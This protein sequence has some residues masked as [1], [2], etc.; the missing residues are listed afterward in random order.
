MSG[1]ITKV[2]AGVEDIDFG[3]GTVTQPRGV[4]R[5]VNAEVIPFSGSEQTSDMVSIAQRIQDI[6]T[7]LANSN[8]ALASQIANSI[9]TLTSSSSRYNFISSEDPTSQTTAGRGNIWF[10]DVSLYSW[11]CIDDTANA[12]VWRNQQTQAIIQ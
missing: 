4:V 5:R 7:A 9:A 3:Q 2:L 10:N 12:Q 6:D 1:Q 8:N 11:I